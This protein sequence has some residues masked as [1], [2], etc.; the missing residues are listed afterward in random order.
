MAKGVSLKKYYKNNKKTGFS[1][2][3]VLIVIAIISTLAFVIV[4]LVNPVEMGR[5]S[6]DAKRLSDLGTIKRA[7]DL[8][9]ADKKTL[10]LTDIIT[11][12][13]VTDI[14]GNGLDISKYLPTIP[15]DPSYSASGGDVR[16]VLKNCTSATANKNSMVYEYKSDGS[17]YVLRAR[18]E[19]LGS[20]TTITEDGYPSDYYELGT[21]PGL[22]LMDE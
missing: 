14:D 13:S 22:N 4:T 8:A 20:C 15:K 21:D 2:I 19:S 1:L 9:L 6:R 12:N 3:E 11:I 10:S 16:V 17:T 18:F 7:I 5:K